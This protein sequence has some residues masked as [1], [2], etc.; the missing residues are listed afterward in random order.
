MLSVLKPATSL[1]KQTQ[2]L[3]GVLAICLIDWE[4]CN[5][6][7]YHPLLHFLFAYIKLRQEAK[8]SLG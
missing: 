8:L 5:S 3:S 2:P 6:L 1:F 7:I 4:C